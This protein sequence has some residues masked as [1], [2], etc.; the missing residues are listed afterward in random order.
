LLEGL[1]PS[2]NHSSL[3]ARL[4]P[5][6]LTLSHGH[7]P[8]RLKVPSLF[9]RRV[10]ELCPL[11]KIRSQVHLARVNG[12]LTETRCGKAGGELT[13]KARK[14]LSLRPFEMRPVKERR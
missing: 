10:L 9:V 14:I 4:T 13:E 6:Q 7:P 2:V 1:R 3:V 5:I 11:A 12:F 8:S